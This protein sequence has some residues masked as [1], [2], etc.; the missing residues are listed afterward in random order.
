MILN[1][2]CGVK[3]WNLST[4]PLLISLVALVGTV[5]PFGKGYYGRLG[6]QK[7]VTNG[8][9]GMGKILDFEKINGLGLTALPF[10]IGTYTPF[11]M[12]RI[13]LLRMPGM[14]GISG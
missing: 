7:W 5:L 11:R 8:R 6:Q 4:I 9:L 13:F 3:L 14:V 12:K 2:N 1:Q 10:S